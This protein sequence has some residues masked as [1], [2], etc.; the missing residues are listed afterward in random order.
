VP[1]T[2]VIIEIC[3]V[4][5][6]T[7]YNH[8]NI[9]YHITE[10]LIFYADKIMVM[11]KSKN[12]R[13]FNFAILLKT[14]KSRKSDAREIYMFYSSKYTAVWLLAIRAYQIGWFFTGWNSCHLQS[15][16]DAVAQYAVSGSTNRCTSAY[17]TVYARRVDNG[18]T[19]TDHHHHHHH[20][21]RHQ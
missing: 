13:V 18:T 21:H 19:V 9:A 16:K 17:Q 1:Q 8:K 14:R 20:H 12:S 11:G 3:P 7:L 2:D 10:V 6:F 15:V 4:L 5:L